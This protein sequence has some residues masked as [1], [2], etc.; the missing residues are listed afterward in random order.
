MQKN[1]LDK[2]VC[3]IQLYY[4]VNVPLYFGVISYNFFNCC[5]NKFIVKGVCMTLYNLATMFAAKTL[6]NQE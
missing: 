1:L 4:F 5:K 3:I 6:L 2:C